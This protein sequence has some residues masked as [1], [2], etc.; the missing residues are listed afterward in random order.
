MEGLGYK[1][2]NKWDLPVS[3]SISLFA[4]PA[5]QAATCSLWN[6]TARRTTERFGRAN[7]T[8]CDRRSLENMGWR[9]HRIWSTDWY[10]RRGRSVQKL[11][12]ALE[13][14]RAA[15][16]TMHPTKNESGPEPFQAK[17]GRA[18]FDSGDA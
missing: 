7:A 14:S 6:V 11:K 8:A 18:S 1:V 5:S 10:Y 16:T 9:F 17:A 4:I 2:D 3:R 13:I 12:T 15:V